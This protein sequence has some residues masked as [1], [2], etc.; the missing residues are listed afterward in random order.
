[1]LM[2]RSRLLRLVFREGKLVYE[3]SDQLTEFDVRCTVQKS[4]F[5]I[6]V[7]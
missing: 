5:L 6:A 4:F 2:G 7:M 3:M 1:M